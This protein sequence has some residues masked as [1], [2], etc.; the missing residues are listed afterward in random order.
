ME[1]SRP[2]RQLTKS[3]LKR[4]F[5][6]ELNLPD[7]RLCP[8]VCA[9]SNTSEWVYYCW[10][11]SK[12]PNRCSN[13]RLVWREHVWLKGLKRLN[14]IL[15]IQDLLD[16]TGNGFSDRYDPDREVIGLDMYVG[17]FSLRTSSSKL[18]IAF[19]RDRIKLHISTSRLLPTTKL[20]IC[21]HGWSP[22]GG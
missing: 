17:R 21:S 5:G 1:D 2:D 16:T 8:P 11:K 13:S 19:Q 14:Y 7:D 10:G 20:E 9:M 4:D 15:W 6:I 22:R 3:L 18:M 12:V